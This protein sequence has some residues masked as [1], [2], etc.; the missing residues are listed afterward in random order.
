MPKT[1]GDIAMPARIISASARLQKAISAFMQDDGC[2]AF[3]VAEAGKLTGILTRARAMEM[4][5]GAGSGAI[6]SVC[7]GDVIVDTP[8]RVDAKTS[9][10]KF[11]FAQLT[12]NTGFSNTGY[13]VIK[14]GKFLGLIYPS[15]L[16]AELARENAVRAKSIKAL[17]TKVATP[18]Q[19]DAPNLDMLSTLAHEI[20]TPLT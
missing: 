16:L 18:A 10:A 12:R 11:A 8:Q 14:N 20:R 6:E 2:K 3:V 13:L 7:V 4:A 5:A 19:K 1:L 15:D 17:K 9:I